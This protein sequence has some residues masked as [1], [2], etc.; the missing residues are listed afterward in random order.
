MLVAGVTAAL[1]PLLPKIGE[2]VARWMDKLFGSKTGKMK[3]DVGTTVLNALLDAITHQAGPGISL[4][5][6]A[7]VRKLL[8]ETV[9]QLNKAGQLKGFD[10]EV[11]APAPTT[12][13]DPDEVPEMVRDL[14]DVAVRLM[15][16]K[17]VGL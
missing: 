17:G 11:G 16:C 5:V 6:E 10:T 2:Q 8:E 7:E 4:P 14:M 1:S 13:P 3:L 9:Q 15:R 12:A